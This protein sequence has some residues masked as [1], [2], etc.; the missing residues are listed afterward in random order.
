M[1]K[2]ELYV[3]G[4]DRIG[5]PCQLEIHGLAVVLALTQLF[6]NVFYGILKPAER[7]QKLLFQTTECFL[8]TKE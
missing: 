6:S 3:F 4:L 2:T 7:I 8:T 5:W 1:H